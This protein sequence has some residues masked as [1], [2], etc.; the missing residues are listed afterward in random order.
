MQRQR[1]HERNVN[2]NAVLL[3]NFYEI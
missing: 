2:Y 1:Q 3:V